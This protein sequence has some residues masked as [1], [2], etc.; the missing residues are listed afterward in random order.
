MVKVDPGSAIR[1]LREEA[2]HLRWTANRVWRE[3]EDLLSRATAL[4]SQAS[5]LEARAEELEDLEEV[6]LIAGDT[7]RGVVR[8]R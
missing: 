2:K 4:K 3:S 6:R 1:M 8:R 7:V 5:S